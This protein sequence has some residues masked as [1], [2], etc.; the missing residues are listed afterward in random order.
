MARGPEASGGGLWFADLIVDAAARA[1][2]PIAAGQRVLDFG[3]SSGRVLGVLGAWRDD[4]AWTDCDPNARA[5]AW[6]DAN[7]PNVSAFASPQEPPLPLEDASL[8]VVYA[9]SVWSHFGET[10]AVRWLSISSP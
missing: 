5:T 8:D 9:I 10:Q 4:I 7:L 6:A 2:A 3:C 1:G